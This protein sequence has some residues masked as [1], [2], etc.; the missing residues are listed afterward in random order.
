MSHHGVFFL[1]ESNALYKR[2]LVHPWCAFSGSVGIRR[3]MTICFNSEFSCKIEGSFGS[4]P[5]TSS[6]NRTIPENKIQLF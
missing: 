2:S 4:K 1:W 5:L 6:V 3:G